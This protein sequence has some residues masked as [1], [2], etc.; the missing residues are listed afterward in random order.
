MISARLETRTLAWR[1]VHLGMKPSEVAG[2]LA[3][4]ISDMGKMLLGELAGTDA[5][6]AKLRAMAS[7]LRF[8]LVQRERAGPS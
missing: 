8:A 2:E 1:L 3:V 6:R 5:Q 7:G 4:S